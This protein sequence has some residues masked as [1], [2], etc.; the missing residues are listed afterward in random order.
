[1]LE[2]AAAADNMSA[3]SLI[4]PEIQTLLNDKDNIQ[5]GRIWDLAAYLSC[6]RNV[7]RAAEL[8]GV[9]KNS[10]YYRLDRISELTQLDLNN[11]GV[12]VQLTLS[13]FLLGFLPFHPSCS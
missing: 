6:G 4:M 11:D 3:D 7:T 9:H 13:L 12:C 10:M 1:M 2:Q 8:R 5:M